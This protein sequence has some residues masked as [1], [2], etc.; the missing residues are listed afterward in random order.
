MGFKYTVV[1]EDWSFG[2]L[3]DAEN[4]QE[5]DNPEDAFALHD[6]IDGVIE[7][8]GTGDYLFNGKV[9]DSVDVKVERA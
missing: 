8:N 5:F 7:S 4:Y 9:F 6:E 3:N 2:E 1:L